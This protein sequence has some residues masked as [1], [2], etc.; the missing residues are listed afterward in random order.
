MNASTVIIQDGTFGQTATADPNSS[1][2]IPGF[3][4]NFIER[5]KGPALQSAV[6]ATCRY[7]AVNR[8]DLRISTCHLHKLISEQ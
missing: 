4:L 1:N 2:A 6:V 7:Y 5:T 8:D 3:R